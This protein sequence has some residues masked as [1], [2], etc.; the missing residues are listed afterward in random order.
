MAYEDRVGR[1]QRKGRVF[2]RLHPAMHHALLVALVLG[3]VC[4]VGLRPAHAQGTVI[5]PIGSSDD[6]AFAVALQPDGKI[7]GAGRAVIGGQNVFAVV[8]LLPTT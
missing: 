5:T 6:E 1:A 3:G 2:R 4:G 7:V 8:R